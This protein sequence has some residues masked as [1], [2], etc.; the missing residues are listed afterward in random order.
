MYI[1]VALSSSV[2]RLVHFGMTVAG[3]TVAPVNTMEKGDT[4]IDRWT[5]LF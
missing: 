3:F 1:G 5:C 2:V 4:L